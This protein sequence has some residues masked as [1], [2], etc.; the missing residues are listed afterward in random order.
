LRGNGLDPA[1]P[2]KEQER[3]RRRCRAYRFA[4]GVLIRTI[5]DE[6]DKVVPAPAQRPNLV[7]EV[8]DF[9]G[10]WGETRTVHLLKKTYWWAGMYDAA[11]KGV[12]ECQQCDRAKASFAV[13]MTGMQSLPIMG[14]GYRWSLDFAGPLVTTRSRKRFVL[15][16]I[17]HFSKW[18]EVWALPSKLST[19]VAEAFLGVMTRYGACAELLTDNGQEFAG[20]LDV[21]CQK[22]L[23]THRT[24]SRYH[25]QS[26]G[27]T[28]RL[29]RTIKGGITRF[30]TENDRRTWDEWLPYLVVMIGPG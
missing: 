29:V 5:T 25:P 15:I 1:W 24:T 22:L 23:I 7:K 27:L 20:E 9:T 19:R 28:E 13:R 30:G 17:E 16:G 4:D 6:E 11:Q 12:A 8:H 18:C 21:L 3:V 2:E 26:N 14:L 10:H